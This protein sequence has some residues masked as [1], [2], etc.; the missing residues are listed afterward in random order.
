MKNAITKILHIDS[1]AQVALNEAYKFEKEINEQV[2]QELKESEERV[3]KEC[4]EQIE[5]M[6]KRL[7][8]E[9]D[10]LVQSVISEKE[11]KLAELQKTYDDNRAR[12][13]DEIVT[14][15]INGD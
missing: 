1:L 5:A 14:N 9:N 4:K 13:E 10:K 8:S 7:H 6:S 3:Q 11:Q 2:E 15:I 12:W